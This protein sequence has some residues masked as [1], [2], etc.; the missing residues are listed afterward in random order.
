LELGAKVQIFIQTKEKNGKKH[1]N[2]VGLTNLLN[3]KEKIFSWIFLRFYF[4]LAFPSTAELNL[5]KELATEISL[6]F[7]S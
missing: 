4:D 1:I 2:N 7:F 3:T 6:K 5:L